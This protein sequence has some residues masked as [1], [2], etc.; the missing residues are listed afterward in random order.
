MRSMSLTGKLLDVGR[1]FSMVPQIGYFFLHTLGDSND[2]G[3]MSFNLPLFDMSSVYYEVTE[4]L[5]Y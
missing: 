4:V 1:S 5:T 3:I 2:Q